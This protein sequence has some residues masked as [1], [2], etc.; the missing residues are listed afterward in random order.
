MV[1]EKFNVTM[2]DTSG[3][4]DAFRI[5]LGLM[6]M[7]AGTSHLT[8]AR[9]EFKG[10]PDW[11][12]LETDSVVLQSGIVEIAF[13]IALAILPRRKRALGRF[14]ATFFTCVFPGNVAQYTHRR[15]AFGLDSDS[16][17]FV[18]LLFQPL[19]IAWA[20]WS[21]SAPKAAE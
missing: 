7:T 13:G 1:P 11:A 12:P 17:R 2:R 4:Q 15:T 21:T 16:K 14:A 8:F 6:L 10:F 3:T 18:R 20:L 5:M 9:D 19:L